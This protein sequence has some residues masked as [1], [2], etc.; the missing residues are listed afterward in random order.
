MGGEDG[1]WG[2]LAGV[3]GGSEEGR[4]VVWDKG[5]G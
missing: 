4:D 2:G 5:K 3:M 1:R